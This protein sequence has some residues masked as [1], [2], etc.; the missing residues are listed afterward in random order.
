[1]FAVSVRMVM[2]VPMRE[3]VF[4]LVRVSVRLFDGLRAPREDEVSM[5]DGI[6]VAV[7]VGAVSVGQFRHAARVPSE[8][9]RHRLGS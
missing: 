7:N 3:L 8:V 1:M 6:G 5:L 4:V 2:V 9:G